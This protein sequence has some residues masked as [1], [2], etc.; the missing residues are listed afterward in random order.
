MGPT[1]DF[2][3]FETLMAQSGLRL[4]QEQLRSVHGGYEGLRAMLARVNRPLPREAE[5][6]LTFD[7]ENV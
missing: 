5:P 7:P 1:I 4:T 3:T 2:A 6:A